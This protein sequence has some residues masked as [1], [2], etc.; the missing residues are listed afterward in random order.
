MSGK[1]LDNLIND[2][3]NNESSVLCHGSRLIRSV[4]KSFRDNNTPLQIIPGLEII[5]VEPKPSHNIVKKTTTFDGRS[6]SI[7]DNNIS[8]NNNNDDGVT[9]DNSVFGKINKYLRSHELKVKF[10]DLIEKNDFKET[11]IGFL[12]NFDE[13]KEISEARKKDKGMG[14]VMIM[15]LMMAKMMAAL[16]LGGIG[17]LAM[18]ALGVSMMALM[19]AGIIGLKS[20][21]H[22][23]HEE[24]GHH[25]QYI[26]AHEGHHRRRRNLNHHILE[27]QT[28]SEIPLPYRGWYN[29]KEEKV[30][31]TDFLTSKTR[32]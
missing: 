19:L 13:G 15:G 1:A 28:P 31:N 26:T 6:N 5:Y 12:K 24:S 32:R 23:G 11:F 30:E 20:L 22:G 2:C 9:D 7:D 4:V 27:H 17:A 8:N 29:T 18:K 14:A 10:A 21:T 3:K 25:V 16:G